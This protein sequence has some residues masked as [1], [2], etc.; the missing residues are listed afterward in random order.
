[1]L[2][3]GRHAARKLKR[4]QILLAADGGTTDEAMA[5]SLAVGASTV[6][7]TKRRFVEGNLER[8]LS[9]TP[10]PGAARKLS[11]PEEALLVATACASPPQGRARWTLELLAGEIVRLTQH[12]RVGVDE[13]EI[14]ALLGRE[15]WIRGGV[16]HAAHPLPGGLAGG[17]HDHTLPG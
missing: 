13:G 11:G 9:E 5:V 15:A 10:R 8:A 4:A 14:L 7:R 6:L 1:M 16:T 17:R 12:A 2:S 3:G